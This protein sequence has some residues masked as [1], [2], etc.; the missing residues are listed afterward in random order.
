[1][2]GFPSSAFWN[3]H[4]EALPPGPG[5]DLDPRGLISVLVRSLLARTA[6]LGVRG[7]DLIASN[8]MHRIQGRTARV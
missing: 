5:L 1:M 4:I 3:A 7:Q 6:A 8:N 2:E